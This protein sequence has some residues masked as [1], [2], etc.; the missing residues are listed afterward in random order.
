MNFHLLNIFFI[1]PCWFSRGCVTGKH[2]PIFSRKA[3]ALGSAPGSE[4]KAMA[5]IGGL[6]YNPIF[7]LRMPLLDRMQWRLRA[8]LDARER[9]RFRERE[10][11]SLRVFSRPR[12]TPTPKSSGSLEDHGIFSGWQFLE[13]HVCQGKCQTIF[14]RVDIIP[15]KKQQQVFGV[16]G[17]KTQRAKQSDHWICPEVG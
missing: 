7:W 13:D 16:G 6:W 2:V 3:S 4:E 12:K 1:S 10:R 5:V 9:G 11:A 14:S 17:R 8:P 15:G